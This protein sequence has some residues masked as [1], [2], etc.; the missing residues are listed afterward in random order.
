M[1]FY[2]VSRKQYYSY[3]DIAHKGDARPFI[4][5]IAQCTDEVLDMYLK[6]ATKLSIEGSPQVIEM[7]DVVLVN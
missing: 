6:G 4:R 2:Y 7:D 1:P 3:L 5:F